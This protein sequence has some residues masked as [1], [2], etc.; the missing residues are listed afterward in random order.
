MLTVKEIREKLKECNLNAVS[1][2]TGLHIQTLYKIKN[3]SPDPRHSTVRILSEY[4][5]SQGS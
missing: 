4:F 2:D 3:E 5:T 1:R